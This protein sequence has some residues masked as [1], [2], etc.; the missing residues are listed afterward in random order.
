MI[1]REN[2]RCLPSICGYLQEL[3]GYA[4]ANKLVQ[5]HTNIHH[6]NLRGKGKCALTKVKCAEIHK[7]Y[8][9]YLLCLQQ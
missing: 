4:F 7:S 6:S 5:M 8:A 3:I 1:N 9:A 2:M